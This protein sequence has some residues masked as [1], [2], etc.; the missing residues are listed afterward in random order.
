MLV[1]E[2]VSHGLDRKII[3]EHQKLK[4]IGGCCRTETEATRRHPGFIGGTQ[5]ISTPL[6]NP[7]FK[8]II[9]L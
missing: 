9:G 2:L 7:K 3:E 4:G 6:L 1:F 8:G 5:E